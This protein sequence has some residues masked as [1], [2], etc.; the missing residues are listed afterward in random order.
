MTEVEDQQQRWVADDKRAVKSKKSAKA[1][2]DTVAQ[3]IDLKSVLL[4]AQQMVVDYMERYAS[5]VHIVRVVGMRKWVPV[6][7]LRRVARS[8]CT[9]ARVGKRASGLDR[10]LPG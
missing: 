7:N 9:E 5:M 10:S 1:H 3:L 2:H 8:G 4:V 6:A